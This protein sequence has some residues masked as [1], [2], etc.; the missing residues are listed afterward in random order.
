[1]L[2]EGAV[3]WAVTGM[4]TSLLVAQQVFHY[5]ERQQWA[6]RLMAKSLPQFKKTQEPIIKMRSAQS[7]KDKPWYESLDPPNNTLKRR[8][9]K[10]RHKNKYT[11]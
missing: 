8:G 2:I 3:F 11:T 10:K 9:D 6:D 4:L 5:R 7:N 1:M